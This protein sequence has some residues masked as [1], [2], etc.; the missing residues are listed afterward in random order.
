M[1]AADERVANKELNVTDWYFSK[2]KV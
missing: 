2:K 1:K